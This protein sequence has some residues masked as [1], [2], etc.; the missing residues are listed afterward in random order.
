MPSEQ[1]DLVDD[2]NRPTGQTELRSV[3]HSTGLW[4]RTV[5]IYLFRK[6]SNK[7]DFLVHL[8]SRNKDLHPNCWD[9]RF[10]GHIK[11]GESVEEAIF[12]E[13]KEELGVILDISKLIGGKWRKRNNYPNCEF[14]KIY[15]LEYNSSLQDLTFNDG[16]VQEV[17]W[18][19]VG[20]I[21]N[22]MNQNPKQWSGSRENFEQI[23]DFLANKLSYQQE[24]C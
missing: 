13:V 6:T 10:G 9:T 17:K 21:I 11:S 18:L 24:V 20:E 3:V 22:S 2:K 15:Y 16:E 4:H 1:L 14:T 19:S 12:N 7:I 8:R 23:S 5:H